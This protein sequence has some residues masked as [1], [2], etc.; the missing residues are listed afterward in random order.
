MFYVKDLDQFRQEDQKDI[1][2]THVMAYT[3]KINTLYIINKIVAT[4]YKQCY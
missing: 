4:D 3:V 1:T 2:F